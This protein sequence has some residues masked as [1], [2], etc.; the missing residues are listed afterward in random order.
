METSGTG[1]R[2][3]RP[4]LDATQDLDDLRQLVVWVEERRAMLLAKGQHTGD[5][6]FVL[7]TLRRELDTVLRIL[8]RWN[9]R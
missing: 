9:G 3:G 4:A 8:D 5:A 6:D 2:C 1:P 7:E